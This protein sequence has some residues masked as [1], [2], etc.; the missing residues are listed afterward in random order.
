MGLYYKT[1]GMPWQ[2]WSQQNPDQHREGEWIYRIEETDLS[3]HITRKREGESASR[4]FS[5]EEIPASLY[6]RMQR[7]LDLLRR[8]NKYLPEDL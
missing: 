7:K 3:V 6:E 1:D 4:V 5:R 2:F 8:T